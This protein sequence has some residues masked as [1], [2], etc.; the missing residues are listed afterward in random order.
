MPQTEQDIPRTT[1]A[2][3]GATTAG[4]DDPLSH[5]HKMSTTAGLGSG[6]YVAVNGAAV[7]ALILGIASAL[8]LLEDYLLV[9]PV[10]CVI[11]SVVAWIQINHSNGTQTG[12]G[13]IAIA[14]I[15]SLGFGGITGWKKINEGLKTRADRQAISELITGFG[16]DVRDGKFDAAYER[17]SDR[18]QSRI[19]REKFDAQLKIIRENPTWGALHGFKWNGLVEFMT[20]ESSGSLFAVAPVIFDTEKGQ[21]R[22]SDDVPMRKQNG[23]WKIDNIPILFGSGQQQQGGSRGAAGSA[24]AAGS[25]GGS[26]GPGQ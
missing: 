7:F 5:L 4:G 23:V 26:A 10:L 6:E 1:T 12:K 8:I 20:E 21:G 18:F 17:T 3:A 14:L 11:V 13:L 2:P 16:N 22:L 19:A 24:G 9:L 15:C 25:S